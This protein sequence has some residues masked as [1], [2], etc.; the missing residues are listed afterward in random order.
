MSSDN[1]NTL[2]DYSGPWRDGTLLV[3]RRDSNMPA[4]C[5]RCAAP[6]AHLN[7]VTLHWHPRHGKRGFG[8]GAGLDLLAETQSFRLRYGYCDMHRPFIGAHLASNLLGVLAGGLLVLGRLTTLATKP[9]WPMVFIFIVAG[10]ALLLA[11]IASVWPRE[12]RIV[13][14]TPGG[15]AWISGFGEAHL[16]QL[17]PLPPDY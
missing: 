6:S 7:Q 5:M 4:R 8:V 17:P 10:V 1:P 14:I 9:G 15:T 2:D 12:A 11:I 3:V 16:A 13:R